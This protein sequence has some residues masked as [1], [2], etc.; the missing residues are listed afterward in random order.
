MK[1]E[2]DLKAE[3]GCIIT[4]VTPRDVEDRMIVLRQQPVLLD[5]DVATLYGVKTKK[6]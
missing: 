3:T 5:Y 6:K 4:Q 1:R 2:V